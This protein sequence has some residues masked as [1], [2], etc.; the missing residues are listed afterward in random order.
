[1]HAG[2]CESVKILIDLPDTTIKK[3][4]RVQ[5]IAVCLVL[6]NENSEESTKENL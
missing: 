2:K 5:N 3:L 1:M 6:G 4:Q